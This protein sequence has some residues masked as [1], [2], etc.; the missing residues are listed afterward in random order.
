MMDRQLLE[1]VVYREDPKLHHHLFQ[2]D[3]TSTSGMRDF[4]RLI[5]VDTAGIQD[6]HISSI[7]RKVQS[8][9]EAWK[10]SFT[11]LDEYKSKKKNFEQDAFA[12]GNEAMLSLN[13]CN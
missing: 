6:R 1:I 2:S 11:K 13:R 7:H 9:A 4:L 5:K 3:L 12:K 10:D 8:L